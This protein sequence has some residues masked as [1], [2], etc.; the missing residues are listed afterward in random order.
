MKSQ[1]VISL[2]LLLCAAPVLADRGVTPTIVARSQG[3]NAVDKVAGLTNKVNL[4]DEG[5]YVNVDATVGYN[6][7][8]RSNKLAQ[9]LFGDD[10]V[11]CNSILVQGTEVSN[12]NAKAWLADYFYLAP[13]YDS[14]FSI[15]PRIQNF[16]ADLQLYVGLDNVLEGLYFRA[17]GPITHSRWNLNFY[18]PC[19]VVASG[20]FVEGYFNIQGMNNDALL[21]TMGD[22]LRGESPINTAGQQDS[23]DNIILPNGVQFDGLNYAKIDR[24]ARSRTGFADLRMELGYNFFQSDKGHFGLN[25]QVAAPSGSRR[26]AQ[27]A[28]DPVIGNGNHWEVG[29][30]L[31]AHYTFWRGQN[32]DRSAGFYLDASLTHINNGREQRTFDLNSRPNSR[33]MLAEKMGRPVAY[34]GASTDASAD[35]G[36]NVVTPIAQFQGRFAP[37]A[38]LTTIDVNVRASI[39][40]DIVA[41]FNY[42]SRNWA[43]DLG[44]NF[45]ARSC[46]KI[47]PVKGQTDDC[48]ENLCTSPIDS[49]ALKGDASVFGFQAVTSAPVTANDAIALSATQCGATIHKGTNADADVSDCT[50]NAKQNCGVDN[51]EFAYGNGNRRLI[52]TTSTEGGFN[53]ASE[54]IKTSL[55]P[56]FINCCDIDLKRTRGVSHKIFFNANYTWELDG[57]VPYIGLGASAEFGKHSSDS[58]CQVDEIDCSTSC[59]PSACCDTKSSC[60]DCALSQWAV[61]AKGG[62]NFN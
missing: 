27:F 38:N 60:L 55:Q 62:I 56:L 23:S 39:Q 28:F 18:E 44:Y 59:D 20:S 34:L 36:T 41:M 7:T 11:D 1:K 5:K 45:W 32:E 3:R 47:S 57:W 37:V 50:D 43:L 13:D 54:H 6:Q 29:G 22:F 42:S 16:L 48:C 46:E 15:K 19:D 58:C 40:A 4:F 35:P 8:F 26:M 9:C 52:H 24:C 2:L 10:I 61:W 30:G 31:S 12:R 21:D 49:W 53:V 17:H 25:V 33:Y 51:A 14:S